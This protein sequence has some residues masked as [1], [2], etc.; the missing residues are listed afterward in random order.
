MVDTISVLKMCFKLSGRMILLEALI[1]ARITSVSTI[2]TLRK[3]AL[4]LRKIQAMIG[5]THFLKCSSMMKRLRSLNKEFTGLLVKWAVEEISNLV[6]NTPCIKV[7]LLAL[8]ILD[9]ARFY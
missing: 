9:V 3:F 5:Q 6:I 2:L 4:A 8:K 1:L 7:D